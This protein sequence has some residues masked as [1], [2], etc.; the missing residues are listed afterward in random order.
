[1]GAPSAR[2]PYILIYPK[3]NLHLV[4][5]GA[6]HFERFP[7]AN[8]GCLLVQSTSELAIHPGRQIPATAFMAQV[9]HMNDWVHYRLDAKTRNYLPYDKCPNV[10][11]VIAVGA[12]NTP[13]REIEFSIGQAKLEV[14]AERLIFTKSP[15]TETN[16]S[17]PISNWSQFNLN[18]HRLW[19]ACNWLPSLQGHGYPEPIQSPDQ[20]PGNRRPF[21]YHS[22]TSMQACYR[23]QEVPRLC[24]SQG[25]FLFQFQVSLAPK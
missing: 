16:G 9:R 10:Q 5:V 24:H 14:M 13:A 2:R 8:D 1:M 20:P 17:D 7:M 21:A 4:G 22:P 6:D 23:M 12:E 25:A 18:R 15:S 11:I 19:V 3:T